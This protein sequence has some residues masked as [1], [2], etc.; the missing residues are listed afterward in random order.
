MPWTNQTTGDGDWDSAS[1]GSGAWNNY[2]RGYTWQQ[3]TM[4]WA[5]LQDTWETLQP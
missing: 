5:R 4:S 1:G 3:A 2:L